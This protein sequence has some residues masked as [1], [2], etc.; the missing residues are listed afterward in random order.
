[1]PTL[2]A[3]AVAAIEAYEAGATKLVIQGAL[4]VTWTQKS[5][6]PDHYRQSGCSA[7]VHTDDPSDDLVSA[8]AKA[9]TESPHVEEL[10]L[11]RPVGS[12]EVPHGGH[13]A[14]HARSHLRHAHPQRPRVHAPL[15]QCPAT[16]MSSN[17]TKLL[18][19]ALKTCSRLRR[20]ILAGT[21][22]ALHNPKLGGVFM[23]P[24]SV[25]L[26]VSLRVRWCTIDSHGGATAATCGPVCHG[27]SYPMGV[28]GRQYHWRCR[29]S[30]FE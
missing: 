24:W 7:A 15:V 5:A 20:L 19:R 14:H 9:L 1:M 6:C 16:R 26:T 30:D 13:A 29:R 18:S 10:E 4:A 2:S 27:W 28:C 3:A 25:S 23:R 22:T 17:A 8:V 11:R 21:C 12:G